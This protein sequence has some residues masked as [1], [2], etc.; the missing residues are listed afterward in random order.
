MDLSPVEAFDNLAR[1]VATLQHSVADFVMIGS[2]TLSLNLEHNS[3]SSFSGLIYLNKLKVTVCMTAVE[4]S[5]FLEHIDMI[6]DGR[7]VM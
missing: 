7:C 5:L 6:A 3:L 4:T 2:L 1:S